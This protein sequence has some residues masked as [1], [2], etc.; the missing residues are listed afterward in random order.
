MWL[1][2]SGVGDSLLA[3]QR[4]RRIRFES[5]EVGS[6]IQNVRRG[7]ESLARAEIRSEEAIDKI[8]RGSRLD[9]V[10]IFVA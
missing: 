4:R 2:A 1:A 9:W 6:V 5:E 8:E 3:E 10:V 7:L